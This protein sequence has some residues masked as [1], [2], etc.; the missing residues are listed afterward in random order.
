[1]FYLNYEKHFYQLQNSNYYNINIYS[2]IIQFQSLIFYK[3]FRLKYKL[4]ISNNE[5]TRLAKQ[6]TR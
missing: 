5:P 3:G 2:I 1:M 6:D 4:D